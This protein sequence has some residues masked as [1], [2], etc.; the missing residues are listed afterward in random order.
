MAL[1]ILIVSHGGLRGRFAIVVETL[2]ERGHAGHLCL[3]GKVQPRV[4]SLL[5]ELVEQ[6]PN[7]TW[8]VGP[9]RGD[10]DGWRAVAKTVRDLGDL[11]H[12][13]HPRFD[14][15]PGLRKRMRK[16]VLARLHRKVVQEPVGLWVAQHVAAR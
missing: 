4:A 3:T 2:A 11:A 12:H 14:A 6:F 1:R 7:L 10:A 9:R 15:A 16:Q 5:A 8:G 13:A